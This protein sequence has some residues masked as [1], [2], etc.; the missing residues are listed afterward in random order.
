MRAPLTVPLLLTA[1]LGP[2]AAQPSPVQGGETLLWVP[3][4]TGAWTFDVGGESRLFPVG[5]GDEAPTPEAH[6]R[7]HVGFL[8]YLD[9]HGRL[10]W[11]GYVG[12][13]FS[14]ESDQ[15]PRPADSSRL[16]VGLWLRTRGISNDF[17]RGSLG[18]F[19]EGGPQFLGE[20]LGPRGARDDLGWREAG[21]VEMGFGLLWY[22]DPF[23]FGE[24]L[25]RLGIE[26]TRVGGASYTAYF[27]GLRLNF[28]WAQ[29]AG[30]SARA[31]PDPEQPPPF[32]PFA[33]PEPP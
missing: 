7:L 2:A 33:D 12:G 27:A 6:L 24:A 16:D 22:L 18:I 19:V 26:S 32:D 10:A 20:P 29:R 25:F 11:G 21:G 14:L 9:G 5:D 28:E 8:D 4:L 31:A 15:Q 13:G 17:V 23:L 30:A 3:R 1:L